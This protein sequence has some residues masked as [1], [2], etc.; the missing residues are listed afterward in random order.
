VGSKVKEH[1]GSGKA[2]L[3]CINDV[4]AVSTIYGLIAE[5]PGIGMNSDAKP[6]KRRP[7]RAFIILLQPMIESY[8]TYEEQ[9][10]LSPYD[11]QDRRSCSRH[12][13]IASEH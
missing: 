1:A 10:R 7:N 6:W 4:D 3:S 12:G 5:R 13:A 9:T 11:G 2:M 8:S